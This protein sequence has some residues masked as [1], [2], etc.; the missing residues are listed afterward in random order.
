MLLHFLDPTGGGGGLLD[1]YELAFSKD[2]LCL[3]FKPTPDLK[4]TGLYTEDNITILV[5]LGFEQRIKVF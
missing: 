2:P 3:S 4:S 1:N 5:I